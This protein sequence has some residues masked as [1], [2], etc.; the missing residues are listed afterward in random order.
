[1]TYGL[2]GEKLGHSFSKQVHKYLFDYEYELKELRPDELKSFFNKK[3]FR[4]INVTIP[5]KQDVIPFLDVI[6]DEAKNI[7]V[8]NT[9]VNRDGKLY[10][11]NT[12][13]LGLKLLIEKTGIEIKGKKV[14]IL[15]SG[16]TSKTAIVVAKD[17][18]C[19][20]VYR[21]SR[22]Q[23]DGCI[24]YKEALKSHTD[25]EVIINT[26]P[27]GMYPSIY[28]SAIDINAFPK[29][30]GVVDA[31]YNPLRSKLVCDAKKRGITA[32]GGLFMLIAQAVFSAEKFTD[33]KIDINKIDEIYNDILLSKQNIVLI[34]M[35]GSGKS[36]VGKALAEELNLNF[37]DTDSEIV[38]LSGSEI[39]DIFA[40]VGEDGFRDLES[41]VIKEVSALQ[42][43]VIATGGGAVLRQEN[44]ELFK[45]NGKIY[46]LDR[47]LSQIEATFDRPLSSNKD[48]LQQRYNERYEIYCKSCDKHIISNTT[49]SDAVKSIKG[50]LLK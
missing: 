4:A 40:K 10:G 47:P 23:T 27:S 42:G 22:K 48:M 44:I 26:T 41:K 43:T 36:T 28:E 50:D 16:G 35:P 1:M 34:G 15:G 11:Y 29:L 14:L 19:R 21:L 6:S 31:V 12:D 17:L 46:F 32:I 9:I 45:E 24:T 13:Y 38:K 7:G 30:S 8:V 25:A 18:E 20:E 33:T 3:Y 39:T 37:V 49:V 2:I 5:Y